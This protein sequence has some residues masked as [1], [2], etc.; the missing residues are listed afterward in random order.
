MEGERANHC[1]A[2][3]QCGSLCKC[4][5]G[6]TFKEHLFHT[7]SLSVCEQQVELRPAAA[8]YVPLHSFIV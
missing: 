2:D 1:S 3:L 8:I 6:H 5:L 4:L 7:P